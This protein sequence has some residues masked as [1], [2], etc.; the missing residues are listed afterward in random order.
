MCD[1]TKAEAISVDR[2]ARQVDARRGIGSVV[3]AVAAAMH[4]DTRPGLAQ[5]AFESAVA[6]VIGKGV[7]ARLHRGRT[8]GAGRT[9]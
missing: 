6:E 9:S 1:H 3:D 8:L 7:Q 5:R 4:A 2:R